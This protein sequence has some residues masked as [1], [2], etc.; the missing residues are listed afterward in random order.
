LKA[1]TRTRTSASGLEV[2]SLRDR[3]GWVIRLAGELDLSNTSL[4]E[5]ALETAV[6]SDVQRIILELSGLEF[7][8]SSGLRT[9]VVAAR[10]SGADS[11]RL[12]IRRGTSAAVTRV[13]GLTGLDR[14]LPFID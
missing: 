2:E 4:L 14:A 1:E 9:L 7:I 8:D 11:G 3:D 6:R 13:L 10:E 5:Q 12:R